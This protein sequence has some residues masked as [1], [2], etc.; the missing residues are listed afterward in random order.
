MKKILFLVGGVCAAAAGFL[1]LGTR[2][3]PPVEMMAKPLETAWADHHTA[4]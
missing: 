3:V 4:A 1:V 2:R